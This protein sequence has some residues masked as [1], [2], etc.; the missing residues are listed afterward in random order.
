VTPGTG[1]ERVRI[2]F[3]DHCARM[4]GAE[5]ALL[6]MVPGLQEVDP[7]VVLGEDGPLRL[8]FEEAGIPVLILPLAERTSTLRRDRVGGTLPL[9]AAVDVITYVWR[10]RGLLRDR[11]IEVVHTNS[12]KACLYGSVAGRLAGLPV[13]W[14]ARDRYATDYLPRAAVR[15]VR[16]AA[17]LFATVVVANSQTTLATLAPH[18]RLQKRVVLPSPLAGGQRRAG[19]RQLD[20]RRTAERRS[21]PLVIGMVGRIS[22]WKGQDV[23]LRA[24]AEAFSGP[25]ATPVRARI[26]GSAL[27]GEEAHAEEMKR[28]AD[29]LG[30]A[31]LVEW[32]GFRDDMIAEL[33]ELDVLVHCSTLPEPFG[34]VVVE[35][36]AA[37]LPVVSTDVGGPAEV[38][39]D[40]R[41]GILVRPGDPAALARVLR[42]LADDPDERDRL[43]ESAHTASAQYSLQI[44]AAR[45]DEIAR[46]VARRSVRA[47]ESSS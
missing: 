36:M 6:R 19:R 13:I 40:G 44:V 11:G 9:S 1:S 35:G 23:F 24:I 29:E 45:F 27:F 20:E 32:R 26:I 34:Q 41:S 10:V 30:I 33:G 14:H 7:L 39:D 5:M 47:G 8:R 28:L 37:G 12:L 4:S 46:M 15:L 43:G 31:D 22:P 38:I 18:P 2:A 3:L 42:R 25:G 16:F 21:G 17:R